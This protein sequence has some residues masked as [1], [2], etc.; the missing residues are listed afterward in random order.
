[1][2]LCEAER[3]QYGVFVKR[4]SR[5]SAKKTR[6]EAVFIGFRSAQTHHGCSYAHIQRIAGLNNGKRFAFVEFIGVS[7]PYF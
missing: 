5:K 2:I 3:R 6:Y 4:R 7:A 1:M